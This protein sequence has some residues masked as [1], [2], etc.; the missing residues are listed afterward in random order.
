MPTT[1]SASQTGRCWTSFS[2]IRAAT[3]VTSTS[4]A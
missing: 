4:I 3:A 1:L 2:R